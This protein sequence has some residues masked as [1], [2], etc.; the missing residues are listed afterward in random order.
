[1][2]EIKE[3]PIC[4][5]TSLKPHLTCKDY[6]VSGESFPVQKCYECDFLITTPRPDRLDPYYLSN[7]YLSHADQAK[8]LFG[9]IYG[10]AR[11]MT[12]RWKVKTLEKLHQGSSPRVL[13]FGCGAGVFLSAC[14]KQ[15]WSISGVEPSAT[16]RTIASRNTAEDIASDIADIRGNFDLITMWHVLEHVP[17]LDVTINNLKERLNPNGHLVVAVPNHNSLDAKHYGQIWA[18][19][20]VPRH[21]W[22]FSQNAMTKLL[23]KHGMKIKET[24]PM[25]L[26][27]FYVSMLSEKYK[28]NTHSMFGMLVATAKGMQSN[29]YSGKAKEYSSLIY[30]AT[31]T[32]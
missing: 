10:I 1:M 25:K 28:R 32:R 21:L 4:Q 16:A 22:H 9:H 2:T 30:I 13:D 17:D 27:A 3:C 14:K 6:T 18:A 11:K 26:D 15:G 20:D 5:G 29:I 23:A 31:K 8:N 7:D 19:Y 24:I 12:T